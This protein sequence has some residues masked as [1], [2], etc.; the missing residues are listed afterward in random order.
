MCL[1]LDGV[2]GKD[3]YQPITVNKYKETEFIPSETVKYF[4]SSKEKNFRPL[5]FGNVPHLLIKGSISID[6]A[7]II[8]LSD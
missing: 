3:A 6:L 5:L 4:A 2:K 8:S 7:E 1:Y